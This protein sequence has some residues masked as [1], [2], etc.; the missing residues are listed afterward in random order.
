VAP[1]WSIEDAAAAGTSGLHRNSEAD[2]KQR[3]LWA[4]SAVWLGLLVAGLVAW[5]R[6]STPAPVAPAS[7]PQAVAL[8]PDAVPAAPA[9]SAIRFPIDTGASVPRPAPNNL[10]DALVDRLGRKA[11]LE[12]LNVD[13]FAHRVAATVDNLARTHAPARFW[14]V[15]PTAGRFA[16]QQ[17]GEGAVI[18]AENSRRYGLFVKWVDSLDMKG[19]AGLYRQLYPEFQSA[20]EAL[21]Y[22]GRYFNDRV[23]DVIDHLLETPSVDEPVAVKLADIKGPIQPARPWVIVEFADASLESRSAG[24]KLL[25]RMGPDHARTLKAKLRQLRSELTPQR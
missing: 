12:F 9:A 23:V 20:Y 19:V 14:P 24:Q 5:Q 15:H 18:G 2:M 4:L 17:M 3:T 21:G 10:A 22:P 6:Q 1:K 13:A 8:A 11:V 7:A 25:L 16:T